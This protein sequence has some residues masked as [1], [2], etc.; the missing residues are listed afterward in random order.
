MKPTLR[1]GGLVRASAS[2]DLRETI[3]VW[4]CYERFCDERFAGEATG[5]DEFLGL[6]RSK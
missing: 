6:R 4:Y 2:L 3:A 5:S 1:K